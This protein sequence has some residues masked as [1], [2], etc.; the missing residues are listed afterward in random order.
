MLSSSQSYSRYETCKSDTVTCKSDTVICKSGDGQ[1]E[2][3]HKVTVIML[4]NENFI[5]PQIRLLAENY[6]PVAKRY[7][8][9]PDILFYIR[10]RNPQVP[11]LPLHVWQ[12][13]F[14]RQDKVSDLQISVVDLQD[15]VAELGDGQAEI[16]KETNK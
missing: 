3:R 8:Q 6:V 2:I 7:E 10:Y 5:K 15:K 11:D 4:E 1:A 16:T 12:I 14:Y 13:V 9:V